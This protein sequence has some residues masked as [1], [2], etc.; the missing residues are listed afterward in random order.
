MVVSYRSCSR[1]LAIRSPVDDFARAA[2]EPDLAAILEH[3]V[4]DACRLARLR[5]DMRHVRDMDRQLFLDDAAGLAH[6]G[7]SMPLGDVH[8]LND[9][10]VLIGENAQHFAGPAL[11]ATANDDDIVALLDLQFRHVCT[12]SPLFPLAGG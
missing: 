1:A 11:V 5:V 7:S 10:P 2:G 8:A 9:D 6:V 3:S 12:P 4:P